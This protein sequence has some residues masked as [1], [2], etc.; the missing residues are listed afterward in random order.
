MLEYLE[1]KKEKISPYFF[2]SFYLYI[3]NEQ[4]MKTRVLMEMHRFDSV[5]YNPFLN[6]FIYSIS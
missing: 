2:F 5:E 4:D 6:S 3:V 1:A